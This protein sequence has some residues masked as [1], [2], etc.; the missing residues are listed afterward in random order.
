MILCGFP[1]LLFSMFHDFTLNM[2]LAME[3]GEV[4]VGG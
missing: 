4:S 2:V 3:L 1:F